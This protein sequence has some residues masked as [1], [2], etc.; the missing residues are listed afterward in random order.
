M[1]TGHN[2]EKKITRKN[3]QNNKDLILVTGATGYVGGRLVPHLIESGYRVRVLVRDARRLQGRSWAEQV[4]VYEGDV[5]KP[6]TLEPAMKE[7]HAAYYMIH[8]MM[9]SSEFHQR[10]LIAARN[11]GQAAKA[12]DVK[13]IIYLGGLGESDSDLSPHLRSRQETGE[14][15]RQSGVPVTEFRAAVIV[16]SGS[17]SFE[18]IRYL[19]ERL[20]LMI[21]PQWVF[22]RVQPISIRN[23]LE[24]LIAALNS[25][26]SAGKVIEIGGKEILT[27]GDMMLQYAEVRG[28]RR[29]LIPV[30]VLTPRL[31]SHW[32][33]WMTPIPAGIAQPLI[34]GLRNE[35]IVNDD[36]AI[37]LFPHINLIDYRTAV[38]RALE[39]LQVSDIETT[40]SDA[41]ASS[42]GDRPSVELKNQEGMIIERR[43]EIVEASPRSIYETICSLGGER[44]W[45]YMDWA[46]RLRGV[47]DRLVGGA[48]LR[49]GRRHPTEVRVG[50]ALDFWRVEAV[51]QNHML[52]LRAEMKVPGRAWLQFEVDQL[53]ADRSFL[54]QSAYF[55][56]RGLFGFLY[57]YVLY[58]LHALIFS[59]MIRALSIEA[60]KNEESG[61]VGQQHIID[62]TLA[63]IPI[64]NRPQVKVKSRTSK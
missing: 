6:E 34:E 63:S 43:Q 31:S 27:Y 28:L 21:C 33:H 29:L 10:D 56:P 59:G 45:L 14:V 39:H 15:L 30:P 17:I 62:G 11:F 53:D 35:V 55:A 58:P 47:I 7:V 25:S 64:E 26:E 51:E 4:E 40:W 37:H 49:R 57:W 52:R 50:D 19:T 1:I 18:M 44:G 13:R 61:T 32:V 60:V 41:M 36:L 12:S 38:G 8:S 24:Y 2:P 42:Q 5:F 46:W 48:G 16:G 3:M 23:V 9:N 22:T 20:P 54:A